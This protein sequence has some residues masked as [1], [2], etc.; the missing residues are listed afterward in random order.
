MTQHAAPR[1]SA[2]PGILPRLL[3]LAA[4][5]LLSA[6]PARAGDAALIE[7]L[8]Y[9][10]DGDHFAFEEFGIQEGSG[11]AYSTIYVV[12]L[13]TDSWVKGTPFRAQAGEADAERPLAKVRAD[14]RAL[15]K[16]Q[17]EALAIEVPTQILALI[18][19]GTIDD[20]ATQ[21]RFADP[22]CCGIATVSETEQVLKLTTFESDAGF[23][24]VALTEQ[25][26]L[27]YAL[28]LAVDGVEREVHRDKGV[29]PKSRG[30]PMGYRLYGVVR[31]FDGGG[32][33]AIVAVHAFG[34][35]G[36]DRRF[37][38]VPLVD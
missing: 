18:G 34:F 16:G 28:T 32:H 23:D 4:F 20:D 24:C 33:V 14:A 19:D 1:G 25:K 27:G 30:C 29:L 2:R 10:T 22:A 11:Y 7:F 38:A 5:I 37:L 8:G 13:S 9:S 35:E 12:Q 21:L 3:L 17:L 36:P 6:L 31:S 26:A 15:A